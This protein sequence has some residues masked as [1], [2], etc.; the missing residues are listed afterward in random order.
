MHTHRD[1]QT[2]IDANSTQELTDRHSCEQHTD[3]T[4]WHSQACQ[5]ARRCPQTLLGAH[6][7]NEGAPLHVVSGLASTQLC[8]VPGRSWAGLHCLPQSSD[9]DAF[10]PAV[11]LPLLH[12]APIS[13]TGQPG[14]A[15]LSGVP[16]A[17]S[18]LLGGTFPHAPCP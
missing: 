9:D 8:C 1:S 11:V 16:L 15:P 7:V 12:H 6:G 10:I 17:A 5:D 4:P 3:V 2:G 13:R 14:M 18:A